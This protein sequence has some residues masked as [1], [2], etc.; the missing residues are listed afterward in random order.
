MTDDDEVVDRKT[1]D[2]VVRMVFV[3]GS[4]IG[5]ILGAVS[6]AILFIVL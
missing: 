2:G 1:F 4:V 3:V 5:A 6:T